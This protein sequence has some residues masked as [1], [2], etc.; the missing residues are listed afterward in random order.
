[1]TEC[2]KPGV[3]FWA[4]VV[5]AMLLLY[6]VSIGPAC[7]LAGRNCVP[8]WAVGPGETIYQPAIWL[9]QNGPEPIGNAIVWY[10][11][12]WLPPWHLDTQPEYLGEKQS[13]M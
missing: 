9:V 11:A 10:A 2:K 1:M 3:A 6:V 13:L 4:T 12:F 5:V 8:D 7:W